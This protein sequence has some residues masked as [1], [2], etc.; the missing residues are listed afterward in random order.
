M[1][2]FFG[3]YYYYAVPLQIL[4]ILHAVKTGRKDWLYLLIFLPLIGTLIYFYVELL[5]EI[6]RGTFLNNLQK[7]FL[8]KQKIKNWERKVQIT[9][10]ITNKLGLSSAY[11]EQRQ[12]DNAVDIALE[13]MKGRYAD[14]P[15][16]ILHLARLYFESEKYLE[17]LKYFDTAKAKLGNHFRIPED[18]LLYI[19]A[20]EGLGLSERAEEGYQ[21]II[22]IHHSLEARYYYGL[23]L[24]KNN[25]KAEAKEQFKTLREEIK[26]LPRY[27][28]RRNSYLAIRSFKEMLS[29]R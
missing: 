19:R 18:E 9:D 11:A 3:N 23:F 7:Y 29:L 1:L 13:C 22:R 14:D 15:V 25:F 17:S 24:K 2:D 10:S 4:A 26:L 27:L 28:R 8:P 5:P 21:R 12:Y 16:I 20:Q 6:G